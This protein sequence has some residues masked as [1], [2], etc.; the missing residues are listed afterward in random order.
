MLHPPASSVRTLSI[1]LLG[2]PQIL[3]GAPAVTP[4]GP[5]VPLSTTRAEI[6]LN[7]TWRFEPA[8]EAQKKPGSDWGSIQVPG[9]WFPVS[10]TVPGILERGK[11]AAWNNIGE[12]T[13]AAW[14]ERTIEIP[15]DWK[16]REIELNFERVSTDAIVFLDDKEVGK[17]EWP[18]GTINLTPHAKPGSKQNLRLYVVSTPDGVDLDYMGIGQNTARKATLQT[19]GITGDVVLSCRPG[20]TWIGGVFIQP[21]VR[22]KNLKLTVEWSGEAPTAPVKGEVVA[23][24]WPTGEVAKRWPIELPGGAASTVDF[25]WEDPR[26]WDYKRPNLYTLTVTTSLDSITERFGFREWRIDGRTLLLNEVPYRPQPVNLSSGWLTPPGFGNYRAIGAMLDLHLDRGIGLGWEWPENFLQRGKP[27][28]QKALTTVADEKGFPMLG[29]L[30]RLNEFVNDAKFDTV[31]TQNKE[32]WEKIT[33]AEWRKYRNHPSINGWILSG[34]LGPHHSD[35]NPR[36]IGKANWQTSET[37]EILEGVKTFMHGIDPSRSVLFAAATWP[38]DIYS[39]MTYLNFIPLQEREEWLSEWAKAGTMPYIAVEFGTPLMNSFMRG[40]NHFGPSGETEPWLTEMAAIYLG[41]DAYKESTEYRRKIREN[42]I[43]GEKF[44]SFN[45]DNTVT[46]DPVYQSIQELFIRNTWRSWRSL[47]SGWVGMLSW[48]DDYNMPA[49]KPND[50]LSLSAEFK[51]GMRGTFPSSVPAHAFNTQHKDGVTHTIRPGGA[52]LLQQGK[53]T[54]AWIA[55]PLDA[56][57]AKDHNFRPGQTIQ[58]QAAFVNDSRGPLDYAAAWSV[59]LAGKEF[60]KGQLKG[61][62]L[63]GAS[64]LAPFEVTL[65]ASEASTGAIG[66]ISLTARIG[67]VDHSDQFSFHIFPPEPKTSPIEGPVLIADFEGKT[68]AWLTSLGVKTQPWNGEPAPGALLIIGNKAL[69]GATGKRLQLAA[70]EAFTTTGGR[71]LIMSQDADWIRENAGFR[72]TRHSTRRM[73][74]VTANHSIMAGV[75]ITALRDWAGSSTLQEAKPTYPINGVPI[76]GWRW[77]QRGVI[78]AACIEKPHFSGWRPIFQSE[79]DLQYT[80]LMELDLGKGRV[81]WCALDLED[82]ATADPAAEKISRNLLKHFAEAPLIPRVVK[83]A[84]SG[85]DQGA[86]FLSSLGLIF[87]RIDTL[88]TPAQLLIIAPDSPLTADV[89]GKQIAL[90]SRV[91]FLAKNNADTDGN[92]FGANIALTQNFSGSVNIPAIPELAGLGAGDLRLKTDLDWPTIA[93]GGPAGFQRLADGMIGMR[94]HGRGVALWTQFGPELLQPKDKEFPEYLRI[95]RWR[96]SRAT[97]QILA[98]LGATFVADSRMFRPKTE[99]IPLAGEWQVQVTQKLPL[100]DWKNKHADPGITAK[101]KALISSADSKGWEKFELPGWYPPFEENCGEAVWKRDVILPS[102]WAGKFVQVNIPAIK[103]Y[104][105]VFWNGQ[106]VDFTSIDTQ[107]AD[108][109]DR[110]RKYRVPGNLVRAGKNTLTIRQF[111]P[112]KQGGIHGNAPGFYL[113]ILSGERAAA[114]L[115]HPDYRESFYTGDEPYRYIRW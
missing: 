85:G 100:V 80:P 6:V 114:P 62:I 66:T 65:P 7:G 50:R 97:C 61:T 5:V 39:A 111:A 1:L 101:A 69:S 30:F 27:F 48:A 56:F 18:G 36:H 104:D 72:V 24:I 86:N 33:A 40:R 77:G 29:S 99:R 64:V 2:I 98:N 79:F 60:A 96:Q 3:L 87:E 71:L 83:T 49:I 82:Q 89:I 32:R 84:Y 93:E 51:P 74:P 76:H 55:G 105:T 8:S 110:P 52:Q 28:Y 13:S 113:R 4:Q 91:L 59:R 53:P 17:L 81:T 22:E 102:E 75:P 15:A 103:S 46:G 107:K 37:T 90:G 78:A 108:P 109:W 57:T 23:K 67:S 35:Q 68:T 92:Y 19:R 63:P 31:W 20:K 10:G 11:D 94:K 25:P 73:W 47:N 115:Y 38:G 16:N 43:T 112:D 70:L 34:N 45:F 26:L 41:P 106:E 88:K 54:L 9:S 95:T 58:K 21:S 42:F 14:Y 44:K 12:N